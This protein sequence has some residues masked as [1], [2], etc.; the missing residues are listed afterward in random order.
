MKNQELE[1]MKIQF[2][3]KLA[4]TKEFV[5]PLQE[6]VNSFLEKI[7]TKNE[8]SGELISIWYD[9]VC[10]GVIEYYE[11]IPTFHYNKNAYT[12]LVEELEEDGLVR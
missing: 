8:F 1:K 9:G 7:V 5:E 3:E 2:A 6:D 10:G 12:D 11:G 4:T